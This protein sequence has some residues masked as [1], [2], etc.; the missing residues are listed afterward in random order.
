MLFTWSCDIC[1]EHWVAVS[2]HHAHNSHDI[3]WTLLLLLITTR[4]F[5]RLLA[6]IKSSY[7]NLSSVHTWWSF[8]QISE[9]LGSIFH[10]GLRKEIYRFSVPKALSPSYQ[11]P[12]S[13]IAINSD[14]DI[15]SF[16]NFS[17]SS[18]VRITI[19]TVSSVKSN[20]DLDLLGWDLI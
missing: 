4:S 18:R 11:M 16:W 2:T 7:R 8:L 3:I 19:K 12:M 5:E 10:F 9:S 14:N 20:L 13:E 15:R 6:G 17:L 1:E